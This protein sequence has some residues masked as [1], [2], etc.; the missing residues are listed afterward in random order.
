MAS[1][2]LKLGNLVVADSVNPVP[3]S[4]RGWRSVTQA[5][6]GQSYLDVEVICSDVD[7]HRRRVEA[8]APDI[9][10]FTLPTWSSVTSHEYVPWAEPHLIVDTS[11]LSAADAVVLIERQI[12]AMVEDRFPVEP[13]CDPKAVAHD[14]R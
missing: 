14:R 12:E 11:L 4:R 13:V 7:E 3:E 5:I 8:R 9:E 2:N 1:S 6:D 10:G